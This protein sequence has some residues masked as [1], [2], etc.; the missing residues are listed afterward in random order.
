[1]VLEHVDTPKEL[2][3]KIIR[4][5]ISNYGGLKIFQVTDVD[6]DNYLFDVKELNTSFK[7]DN[8]RYGG[9]GLGNGKGIISLPQIND[10][11]L[12]AFIDNAEPVILA[13][14]YNVF[15]S[16]K[17]ALLDIHSGEVFI[18]GELNGSYIFIDEDGNIKLKLKSGTNNVILGTLKFPKSDGTS[19]QVLATD[20]NNTLYW[21]TS[22][23]GSSY[24]FNHPLSVGGGNVVSLNYQI[25]EFELNGSNELSIK[26]D[27]IKDYHIDWGTGS[28]QVSADDIPDG[29]VNVIISIAQETNFQNAYDK[30]VDTWGNGLQYSS[31]VASID[32][33]T[34]NL[35]I[36]T[37]QINTI[38]DISTTSDV[39]FNSM[40][41]TLTAT[42]V[43]E[44]GVTATTQS[45][46]DNS[47]KVATT[48]YADDA[49]SIKEDSFV[50]WLFTVGG[51]LIFD[52]NFLLVSQ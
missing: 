8:V 17:D 21:T 29:S 40:T 18:S 22:G 1:M 38:Q 12:V 11:V 7:L 32:Y 37:G 25:D 51:C 45:P 19:G 48:A 20:G 52:N 43:L 9:I 6:Y 36:T 42:S 49:G 3:L 13:S 39:V 26:N 47:T 4:K 15:M 14:I 35:K 33:N 34:T 50:D 28:N 44:D 46:G 10:L 27:A 24:T 41:G 16:E 23:G 31:Q 5:E 30:R 2:L